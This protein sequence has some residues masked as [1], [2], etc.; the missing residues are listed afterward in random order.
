[1]YF[2]DSAIAAYLTRQSSP[3][4]L[5]HG[6]MGGA[7]FEGL[8]V[9]DAIKEISSSGSNAA[10]YFWRSQDGLEVDLIIESHGT[11]F[12][13][14][15]KQTATPTPYHAQGIQKFRNLAGDSCAPGI[16]VCTTAKR[17]TMPFGVLAV[18]WQEFYMWL[19]EQGIVKAA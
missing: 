12:P 8:I 18:P 3:E 7:F 13:V 14:E 16:I 9:L 11:L 17:E 5:W 6:S 2:V 15:I 1:M 10:P 4:S 19:D